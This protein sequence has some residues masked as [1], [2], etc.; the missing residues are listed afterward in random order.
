MHPDKRRAGR[1]IRKQRRQMRRMA[2]RF[3]EVSAAAVAMGSLI[4]KALPRLEAFAAQ[5]SG[6]RLAAN[7]ETESWVAAHA[8]RYPIFEGRWL[9]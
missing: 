4:N 6:F 9:S 8:E 2:E 1:R 5:V 7:P 3:M